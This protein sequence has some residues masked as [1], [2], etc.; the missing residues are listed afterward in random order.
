MKN[1]IN[2]KPTDELHGRA[3]Y[4]T[5]FVKKAD[6]KDKRVLDIGCGYGWF[7][8]FAV[9]NQVKKIVGLEISENDLKTAKKHI[10]D[11]KIDFTTGSAIELPFKDKTFDTLVAWEVI[12]HIPK[13]T[14]SQ[15]FKEA[16]RVLG[17]GGRFY[18]STPNHSV[19]SNFFDPAWWLIGHRHYSPKKLSKIAQENG[20]V[21]EKIIVKG[22][23]WEVVDINNLYICKWIFRTKPLFKSYINRK[24]DYSYK[25]CKGFTNIFIRFKKCK[26]K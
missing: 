12:E 10:K 16:F 21:V 14:E 5:I 20:F 24:Q 17:D 7:E 18:L 25:N 15:M 1:I 23:F 11:K 6:I 19:L 3:L 8:L 26:R 4:N 2:E 13:K 9:E 22:G